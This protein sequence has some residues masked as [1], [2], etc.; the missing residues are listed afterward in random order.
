MLPGIA[1]VPTALAPQRSA[2]QGSPAFTQAQGLARTLLKGVNSCWTASR[3][4]GAR[5]S[6][7]NSRAAEDSVG[8]GPPCAQLAGSGTGQMGLTQSVHGGQEHCN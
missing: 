5:T 8:I 6:D 7:V 3:V 4:E 1:L 2:T